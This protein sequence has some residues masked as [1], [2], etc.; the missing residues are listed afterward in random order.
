M[1]TFTVYQY[2]CDCCGT[3]NNCGCEL[4]TDDGGFILEDWMQ[5]KCCR[6]PGENMMF[7]GTKEETI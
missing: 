2:K 1:K 4:S 7:V 5:C 3:V 6:G